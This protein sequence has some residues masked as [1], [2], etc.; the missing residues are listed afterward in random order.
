[1]RVEPVSAYPPATSRTLAEWMDADL[2]AMHGTDSRSRLREVADA[3]AMRRGMWASFLALG[4]S[5]VVVGLVLLAVGMPPSAYVP[6]MTVGG[7]VAVVSGVF[8]A[9]VRGWIP[10]PGTSHTTRG[11]GSLGGGLIAAAS[12]FG[13]LNVFLIP[14]IVSSV[15]PVPLLVLDAGFALLLVSVFVIPA[16]VIGRGRQTLRREAARDQRL[17]AA[18]ERDRVT[19]V[20][21]VAVPMFGP[22]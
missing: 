12:I 20:P 1:M 10:K 15:D 16:A 9:R 18:L 17:V 2:A 14:G 7:I 8:L 11:A 4:S 21:L 19:W 5:S 13:A 22:L 3:R 6:S